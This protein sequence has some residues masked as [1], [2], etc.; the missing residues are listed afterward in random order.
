VAILAG[1]YFAWSAREG[2]VRLTN[3]AVVFGP[4]GSRIYEQDKVYLT[5][6]EEELLGLSPGSV[7]DGRPFAIAKARVGLTICRDTFFSAWERRLSAS[8]LWVDIKANGT[9]FTEEERRRFEKALPA[10]IRSGQVPYGLTVCLTGQ[11]LDLLWEGVSS[12]VGREPAGEVVTR[13]IAASP[14]TEEILFL[15]VPIAAPGN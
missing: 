2:Q 6:F 9:P 12:L 10:R 3:R 11:L 15:A 1:S 14:R 7:S 8:D 5:P 13:Q 4:D